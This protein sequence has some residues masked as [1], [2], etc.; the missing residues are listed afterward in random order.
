MSWFSPS[1]PLSGYPTFPLAFFP[2]ELSNLQLVS[3]PRFNRQLPLFFIIVFFFKIQN[4]K[5]KK[6]PPKTLSNQATIFL[7]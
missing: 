1:I 6:K 5:F 4:S 7:L 2:P 3:H